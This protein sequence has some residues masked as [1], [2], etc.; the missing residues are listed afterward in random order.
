MTNL[1][2]VLK[3]RHYSAAKRLY[4]QGYGIPSDFP[5]GSDGKESAFNMRDLWELDCKKKK[6]KQNAKDLMPFNYY[7]GEDSWKSLGQQGEQNS[8]S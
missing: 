5:G 2:S 6:K 7:T 3:S 8:Q 1:D 4:N